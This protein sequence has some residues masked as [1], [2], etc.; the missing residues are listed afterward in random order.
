MGLL[1][2]VNISLSLTFIAL[3]IVYIASAGGWYPAII[4][5]GIMCMINPYFAWGFTLD[6]LLYRAVYIQNANPPS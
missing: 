6:K 4:L 5:E 3:I 1:V 2:G